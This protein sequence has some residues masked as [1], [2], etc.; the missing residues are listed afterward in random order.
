MKTFILKYGPI[1]RRLFCGGVCNFYLTIM[2]G[3]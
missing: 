1:L 3:L 2:Q